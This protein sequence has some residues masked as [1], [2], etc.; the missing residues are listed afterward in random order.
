MKRLIETKGEKN[1]DN[2]K[3]NDCFGSNDSFVWLDG[4]RKK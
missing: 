4:L 2:K 1:E 3:N